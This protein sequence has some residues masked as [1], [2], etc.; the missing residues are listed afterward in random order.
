MKLG[1]WKEACITNY[2][3]GDVM[4]QVARNLT[5]CVDGFLLNAKYLIH[6]RDPLFTAAFL[7]ILEDCG[8][9]SVKLPAK[10]PNLNPYAERFIRSIKEQCLNRL[11]LLGEN[12]IRTAVRHFVEH[13]HLERPHQGLNNDLIT[14]A[15][16]DTAIGPVR[17][18]KRLGG[19]IKHYYRLD[20]AA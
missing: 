20:K 10:S 4:K 7:K 18:R 19:L 16:K 12:H 1:V 6:D 9:E 15:R 13:Y 17:C 11:I 3:D 5:D 8:V 14:P 2:V